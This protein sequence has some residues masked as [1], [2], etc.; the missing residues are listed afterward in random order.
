MSKTD[1]FI[2]S[3]INLIKTKNLKKKFYLGSSRQDQ[4]LWGDSGLT[5]GID[6]YKYGSLDFAFYQKN[7][8]WTEPFNKKKVSERPMV[9]IEGSDCL[10]T[11]SWGNAQIQRFHHVYAGFLS[12]LCSIY[13][14]RK[15]DHPIRPELFGV[16]SYLN[17]YYS[18]N[19]KLGSLLIISEFNKLEDLIKKI[20]IFDAPSKEYSEVIL[21]YNSEMEEKFNS[22]FNKFSNWLAYLEK[23][24]IIKTAEGNF[25]KYLG[26]RKK[27]LV[28][29]SQ[30]MGHI[31]IGEA[32][33][34]RFLLEKSKL[35]NPDN[36]YFYYFFPLLTKKEVEQIDIKLQNDKEWR[37]LRK[38]DNK[39]RIVTLDCLS[40]VKPS[41]S[42]K[43][44]N[45][46]RTVNLNHHIKEWKNCKSYIANKLKTG[47]YEIIDY[48]KPKKTTT[49][50]DYL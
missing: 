23:R 40:G 46:F 27:S 3:E 4:K 6:G 11:R 8:Q 13:Y 43:I 41:I 48:V 28:D 39:W 9:V 35:F 29:S 7:Q 50:L 38:P 49:V 22:F 18:D 32:F 36:D 20:D 31:I 45:F 44:Q 34:S 1:D 16:S 37:L 15:G 2:K 19:T 26:P 17:Q 14:L 33:I 30:R 25:V 21:S 24:A 5:F 42:D 47:D 12:D 10:N